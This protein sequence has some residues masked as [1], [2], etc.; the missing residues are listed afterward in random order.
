L[1]ERYIAVNLDT[2]RFFFL[3]GI[4]F[5]TENGS[6]TEIVEIKDH[7]SFIQTALRFRLRKQ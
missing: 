6:L 5:G 1:T 2:K 7:P 4:H 3:K